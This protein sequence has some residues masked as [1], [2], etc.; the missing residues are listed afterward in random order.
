MSETIQASSVLHLVEAFVS[1]E[2]KRHSIQQAWL[3]GSWAYGTP[4]PDSDI[5]VSLVMDSF[6]LDEEIQI[7]R[8]AKKNNVRLETH[9]FSSESFERA[10]RS[11]IQDI[12]T[13]GIRIF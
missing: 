12:K 6:D 10:Q 1:Q 7:F 4:G 9:V 5:D 2:K 11:I 3:F 13:K 8:D